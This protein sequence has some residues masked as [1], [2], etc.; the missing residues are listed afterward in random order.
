ME[1]LEFV[2][3]SCNQPGARDLGLVFAMGQSRWTKPFNLWIG[4]D[5][6]QLV[7]ESEYCYQRYR[8]RCPADAQSGKPR[9]SAQLSPVVYKG[10][11]TR[12]PEIAQLHIRLVCGRLGTP[13]CS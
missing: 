8:K 5:G 6:S 2:V 7:L 11:Q 1:T 3:M 13:D 9:R 4:L 10:K 12:A